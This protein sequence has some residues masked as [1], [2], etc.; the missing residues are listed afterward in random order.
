MTQ[1]IIFKVDSDVKDLLNKK[2]K[3]VNL[4]LSEYLRQIVEQNIK[5]K[6]SP[7]LK[8][9]GILSNA[10]VDSMFEEITKD[11]KSRKD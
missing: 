2:A 7:F 8:L 5:P 11:R 6:E 1:S 4:T 3:K 9:K 10:E